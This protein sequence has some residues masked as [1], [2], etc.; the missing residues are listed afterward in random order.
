VNVTIAA[1][2]ACVS[3]TATAAIDRVFRIVIVGNQTGKGRERALNGREAHSRQT[4][5]HGERAPFLISVTGAPSVTQPPRNARNPPRVS[6]RS[7]DSFATWRSHQKFQRKQLPDIDLRSI[8]GAW[9]TDNVTE[10]AQ[11]PRRRPRDA[12]PAT[13]RSA[14]APGAGTGPTVAK[15]RLSAVA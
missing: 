9:T 15:Y 8:S 5:P 12:T 2:E 14:S 7:R 4:K 10:N 1:E 13:P 3:M 11:A 6:S